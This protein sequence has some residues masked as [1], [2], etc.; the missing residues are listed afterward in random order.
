MPVICLE[1]NTPKGAV[2]QVF[3]NVNTGG[4]SLTVFELVT[5]V[6]AMDNFPLREDWDS[7]KSKHF[8][9]D[10]LR[11]I[12]AT[13]FLQACTLLSNYKKGGKVSCKKNDVLD[14]TLDEFKTYSDALTEGF[15]MAERILQEERIFSSRDLPYTTQLIPLAVLC[16]LLS[17]GNQIKSTSVKDKI[18]KWYWCGV[19]GELYSGASE[20]RYVNDVVGVMEWINDDS[21]APRTVQESYFN[22]TRLLSLQSRQ[23]AAYKGVMALVYKNHCQDFISGEEMDFTLYKSE[24]IDV[25]HIFPRDYCEKQHYPKEKW[26]SVV[27]KTPM[28]GSTNKEIG[29]VAPSKYLAKIEDKGKVSA[30]DLN[31]YIGSH[32]IE[33]DCMRSD[34]F[35]N[36]IINR[37]RKLLS[38]I[39]KAMGKIISGK[40]SQETINA[41][42]G[43]LS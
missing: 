16:T 18:K 22:P 6:F 27:N 25:H 39:E 9:G 10:I 40:D 8:S 24:R 33:V 26:N 4:V 11:I 12:T 30:S 13:D 41:F 20:T 14:L 15:E 31:E 3:E 35:N 28:T 34:D 43:S 37:A 32:W 2:C 1:K 21:S 7:R 23:S 38:A 42:G 17:D 29:C 36:H 19:F 5:A